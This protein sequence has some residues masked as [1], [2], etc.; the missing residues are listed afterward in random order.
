LTIFIKDLSFYA[1]LGIL[2]EERKKPQKIIVNAKITYYY[3]SAYFI[4]YTEVSKLIKS[5]IIKGKFE[6]IE[7]ALEKLLKKIQENFPKIDKIKLQ[8]SKPDILQDCEVGAKIKKN[9][10]KN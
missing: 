3:T 9:F 4:N 6:L 10:K 2:E 5:T 8:I 7:E 1:V